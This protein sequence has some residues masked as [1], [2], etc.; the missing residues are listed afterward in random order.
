M[1]NTIKMFPTISLRMLRLSANDKLSQKE[2]GAFDT[3][4]LYAQKA[5][6]LVREAIREVPDGNDYVIIDR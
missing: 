6:E 1:R 3:P 5:L 4:P 2:L